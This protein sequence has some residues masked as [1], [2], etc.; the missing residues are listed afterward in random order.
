MGVGGAS[1]IHPRLVPSDTPPRNPYSRT[2]VRKI[3]LA[4]VLSY[5]SQNDVIHLWFAAALRRKDKSVSSL[6]HSRSFLFIVFVFSLGGMKMADGD[7]FGGG[8]GIN[9]FQD[10][11]TGDGTTSAVLFTGEL[12]RQAERYLAEGLHPRVLTEGLELAKEH[13]LEVLDSFRCSR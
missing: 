12:L 3:I 8:G 9:L 6:S 7:Y 5:L 2:V 10:D 4:L 1:I 13:T 11:V